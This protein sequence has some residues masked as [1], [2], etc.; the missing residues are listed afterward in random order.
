MHAWMEGRLSDDIVLEQR[1]VEEADLIIFQVRG[2]LATRITKSS[3][4][5]QSPETTAVIP[6]GLYTTEEEQ[7]HSV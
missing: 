1:K 7:D 4:F 3:H 2:H 5:S 6:G